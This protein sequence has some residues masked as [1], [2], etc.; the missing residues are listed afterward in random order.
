VLL[1]FELETGRMHAPPRADAVPYGKGGVAGG[2]PRPPRPKPK[3][4]RMAQAR[5]WAS[6]DEASS[7]DEAAAGF[8]SRRKRAAGAAGGGEA[9]RSSSRS[10]SPAEE[11]WALC[12]ACR[13]WRRL[14]RG[15]RGAA[16]PERWTCERGTWGFRDTTQANA[17]TPLSCALAEPTSSGDAEVP[18]EDG[19]PEAVLW[20]GKD[21]IFAY[22]SAEAAIQRRAQ[23]GASQPASQPPQRAPRVTADGAESAPPA[24]PPAQEQQ[25]Q[26]NDGGDTPVPPAEDE[27]VAMVE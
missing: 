10:P 27:A 6:S 14:P 11:E 23:G 12:D 7:G 4:P 21:W 16:L 17:F 19:A 1:P 24:Q 26:R 22:G 18:P 9:E 2:G 25:Q 3:K 20:E 8:G 15:V 5:G 13:K